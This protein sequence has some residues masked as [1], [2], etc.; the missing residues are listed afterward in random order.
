MVHN[1]LKQFHFLIAQALELAFAPLPG[2][3]STVLPDE[4]HQVRRQVLEWQL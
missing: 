1:A 3:T 2:Q 4:Q